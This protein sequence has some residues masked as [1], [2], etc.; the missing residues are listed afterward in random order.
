[1]KFAIVQHSAAGYKGDPMFEAGLEHR[2]IDTKREIDLVNRVGGV[3]FD[4]YTEADEFEM[5]AMYSHTDALIPDAQG[6][7]SD[8]TI[9]GLKIY[10]P[11]RK[12]VG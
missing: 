10:I 4:T 7:F 6:T 8:K 11:V 9:D 5:E 1:M 2:M 12:V 3:M